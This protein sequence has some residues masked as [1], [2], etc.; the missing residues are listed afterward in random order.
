MS[1]NYDELFKK[2]S[3]KY[4]IGQLLYAPEG[5]IRK[6][7]VKEIKSFP[8]IRNVVY[9]CT[10][11]MTGESCAYNENELYPLG[12]REKCLEAWI[13]MEYQIFHYKGKDLDIEKQEN[14]SI[15]FP[16]SINGRHIY[17]I[18]VSVANDSLLFKDDGNYCTLEEVEDPVDSF[19]NALQKYKNFAEKHN[20]MVMELP[21]RKDFPDMFR[22]DSGIY[23]DWKSYVEKN[24]GNSVKLRMAVCESIN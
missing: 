17:K 22:L 20:G 24:T 1:I 6:V 8:A 21:K 7:S 11:C 2:D 3:S 19:E 12:E 23:V 10:D 4:H 16:K 15:M 5:G 9:M 14:F 18:N 13:S